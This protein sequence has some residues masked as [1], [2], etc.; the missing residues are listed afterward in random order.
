MTKIEWTDATWNPLIGCSKISPGCANCYA[1]KMAWRLANM[2]QHPYRQVIGA[3]GQYDHQANRTVGMQ[4]RWNGKA[5]FIESALTKPLHW[6]KPR[7]IFVV[8]MG[9]LFHESVPFEWISRVYA[10]A[11]WSKWHTMQILTKRPQR[12]AEF[13]RWLGD[14]PFDYLVDL[15]RTFIPERLR[16][17][18]A[19]RDPNIG[20]WPLPNVWLGTTVE[21]Q[22]RADERIPHLLATPAAVRFLSVEPMLEAVDLRFETTVGKV[23]L[24]PSTYGVLDWVI[25]G[26]ESGPNARP[27]NVE[28]IRNI[29]GQCKAASVPVFVK[30]MGAKPY[31]MAFN[32]PAVR[33][34]G[35]AQIQL[36]GEFV[37]IHLKD[38]K[39]GDISEFPEDL[40]VRQYPKDSVR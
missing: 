31:E 25:A 1:E 29:V 32:G 17:H 8:S 11:L 7:R 6:K 39:G 13:Y 20:Q 3:E 2:G 34:W 23:Q 22:Q 40:R 37:Q 4:A 26:G 36:N 9:D 21:D 18:A 30:Q 33:S 28:W 38:G 24:S 12:I 15:G 5:R 16:I 27:C 10:V 35:E 19:F 14:D